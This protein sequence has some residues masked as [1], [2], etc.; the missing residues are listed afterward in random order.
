MGWIRQEGVVR[1][2]VLIIVVVMLAQPGVA[3]VAPT[4]SLPLGVPAP[5]AQASGVARSPSDGVDEGVIGPGDITQTVLTLGGVVLGILASAWVVRTVARRTGG[6]ASAMGPGGRAPS[7]VLEVLGRFPVSRGQ[8]LVLLKLDRRVLLLS[9]RAGEGM[10]TLC[11]V[12]EPDEVAS[13]LLKTQGESERR[14]AERFGG[15]LKRFTQPEP[16]PQAAA[17]APTRR[18]VAQDADGDRVE[19]LTGMTGADAAAAL[20]LRL[21]RL[22]AGD[23]PKGRAS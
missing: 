4:E 2:I 20:R 14:E 7:G 13:L 5:R 10:R 12:T 16:V 11:E 19:L 22:K 17:R 6:L 1:R 8:T 21:A 18:V 15:M 23:L 3:R 9:Q